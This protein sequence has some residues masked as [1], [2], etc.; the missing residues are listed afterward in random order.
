MK[1]LLIPLIL[2]CTS[3]ISA[4]PV[5]QKE[6]ADSLIVQIEEYLNSDHSYYFSSS[7]QE[8]LNSYILLSLSNFAIDIRTNQDLA[9]KSISY[10]IKEKIT[11]KSKK[12]FL[13][14]RQI[15]QAEILAEAKI[16]DNKTSKIEHL[17]NFSKVDESPVQDG[18]IS[19][20]KSTLISLMAGT[21]IYSLWSIE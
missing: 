5:F 6:V 15:R 8:E 3:L 19:L 13:F 17:I 21:L 2:L 9:D 11:L 1:R 18:D 12:S 7:K 4:M 14:S 20:W 10:S 16:I